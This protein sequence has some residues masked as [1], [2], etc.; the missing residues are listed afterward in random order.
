MGAAVDFNQGTEMKRNFTS[1]YLENSTFIPK[2]RVKASSLGWKYSFRSVPTLRNK[3]NY[4]IITMYFPLR[5]RMQDSLVSYV[6]RNFEQ[7]SRN[8]NNNASSARTKGCFQ[9]RP[10]SFDYIDALGRSSSLQYTRLRMKLRLLGIYCIFILTSRFRVDFQ[11][12]F[13]PN[14]NNH[15]SVCSVNT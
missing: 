5:T 6:Q 14:T 3:R 1:Y 11:T 15:V 4:G 10:W 9:R 13:S 7:T 2:L 8:S 12:A